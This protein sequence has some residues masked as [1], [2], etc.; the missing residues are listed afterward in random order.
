MN[1]SDHV[2]EGFDIFSELQREI[3]LIC[4]EV[5]YEFRTYIN[6]HLL[7]F[8]QQHWRAASLKLG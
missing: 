1:V 2:T 7:S 4:D 6:F 3:R 5:F 8:K